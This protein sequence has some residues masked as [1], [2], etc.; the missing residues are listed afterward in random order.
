MD[1]ELAAVIKNEANKANEAAQS[2]DTAVTTLDSQ[3]L[4]EVQTTIVILDN[5]MPN[6]LLDEVHN[7]ALETNQESLPALS[8]LND[9]IE[10]VV[11]PVEPITTNTEENETEVTPKPKNSY[12]KSNKK[13]KTKSIVF[14]F[15]T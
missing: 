11:E 12:K 9:Q 1:A 2:I 7:D 4:N 10:S 15:Y 14:L 8:E 5:E 6:E 13:A 3:I